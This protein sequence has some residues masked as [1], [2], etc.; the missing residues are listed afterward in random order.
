[1][2]FGVYGRGCS[3]SPEEQGAWQVAQLLPHASPGKEIPEEPEPA[4]W[5]GGEGQAGE[6]VLLHL[7]CDLG[8]LPCLW[9]AC[10]D[11]DGLGQAALRPP[12]GASE[13]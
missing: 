10:R 5:V 11:I 1:M 8:G 9:P 12:A 7:L 3:V 13:G 2:A 6:P 4:S